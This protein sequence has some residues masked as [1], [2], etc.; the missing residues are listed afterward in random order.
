MPAMKAMLLFA[1]ISSVLIATWAVAQHVPENPLP[2]ND[3][4]IV[5]EIR[6]EL[7]KLPNFGVFDNITY[8]LHDGTVILRGQVV[9]PSLKPGAENAVKHIQGVQRVENDIEVLPRSSTD[10][11]IRMAEFRS[12]YQYPGMQKYELGMSKPIRIVVKDRHVTLEGV[13]DSE[14]DQ[15]L[16]GV[17]ARQVP[18]TLSVKNNLQ[19]VQP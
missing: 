1:M 13:V 18:G 15:E 11:G 17:R 9:D 8:Q 5:R 16:A 10:D 14:P 2:K 12:I 6:D 19:V 4:Q 7:L 3:S